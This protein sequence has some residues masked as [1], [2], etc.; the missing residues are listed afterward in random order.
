MTD[1]IQVITFMDELERLAL[2]N[3]KLCDDINKCVAKVEKF[4]ER[5]NLG[6]EANTNV[7]TVLELAYRRTSDEG[8]YRICGVWTTDGEVIVKPFSECDRTTKIILFGGM[9]QLLGVLFTNT[10][11]Q[12]QKVEQVHKS[13]TCINGLIPD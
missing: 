12:F 9:Q 4:L 13:I 8:K 11:Q 2:K 1:S 5:L 10:K 3:N 6:I 7:M